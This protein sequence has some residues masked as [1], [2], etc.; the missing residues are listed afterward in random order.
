MYSW[1]QKFASP[2][3][4]KGKFTSIFYLIIFLQ[5]TYIENEISTNKKNPKDYNWGS[6]AALMV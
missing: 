3:E 6:K 2:M 5:F 4:N 1:V